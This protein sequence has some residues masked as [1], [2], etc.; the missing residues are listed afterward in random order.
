MDQ[1]P[2]DSNGA[3]DLRERL[4]RSR[5]FHGIPGP[6]VATVVAGSETRELVPGEALLPAAVLAVRHAPAGVKNPHT[7]TII[8]VR[9][10][11][12]QG[13]FMQVQV[14]PAK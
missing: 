10:V 7:G 4:L 1:R 12:A 2:A 5:L 8:E 11:S 6:L 9:S 13:S 3:D 14:R